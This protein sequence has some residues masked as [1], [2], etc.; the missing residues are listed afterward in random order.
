M[1]WRAEEEEMIQELRMEVKDKE[2]TIKAL[3]AKLSSTEQDVY[4]R[5]R[6]IDILRQSLK[7]MNCKKRPPLI[8]DKKSCS[9]KLHLAVKSHKSS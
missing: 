7:I 6:D 1:Y 3:K 5:E 9:S 8:A 4:R 2:E